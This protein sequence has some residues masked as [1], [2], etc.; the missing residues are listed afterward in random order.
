M[1]LEARG[2]GPAEAGPI[3]G[4]AYCSPLSHRSRP[5]RIRLIAGA[6]LSHRFLR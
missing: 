6:P 5:P 1:I 2:L 4:T 3:Y